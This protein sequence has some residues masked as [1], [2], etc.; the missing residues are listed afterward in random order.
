MLEQNTARGSY[1]IKLLGSNNW[2]PWKC[3]MQ[4]ILRDLGIEEYIE[5][6]S[7]PPVSKTP[8]TEADI[9]VQ[10]EWKTGDAKAQTQI[11]LAIRD[12]E[13]IHI[14]GTTMAREMWKQLTMVKESRGCLGVLAM[15]QA[16]YRATA[17]ESFEMVNHIS[18][19]QN[20]RR[21]YI[22]W[23]AWYLMKTS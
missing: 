20:Y 12:A 5:E 3:Q 11:D 18:E 21:N 6:D 8:P 2:M 4:A 17:N 22:S 1:Y 10:K 16:L 13:I 19:I 14:S 23:E 9:K 7:A 15:H